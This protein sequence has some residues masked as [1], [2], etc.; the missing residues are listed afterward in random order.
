MIRARRCTI[1]CRLAPGPTADL[2]AI[3]RQR[4]AR[5]TPILIQQSIMTDTQTWWEGIRPQVETLHPDQQ[6]LV[7]GMITAMAAQSRAQ[8]ARD[9]FRAAGVTSDDQGHVV[10]PAPLDTTDPE[11]ESLRELV[12]WVEAADPGC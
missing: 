2:L 7:Y 8:E 4:L 3:T 9:R 11:A 5:P 10:L 12:R 6:Q 1:R